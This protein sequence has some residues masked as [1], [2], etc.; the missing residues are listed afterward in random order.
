MIYGYK[1]LHRAEDWR[2]IVGIDKWVPGRSAY[3]LAYQW[4]AEKLPPS[5]RSAFDC[6]GVPELQFLRV[7]CLFVEHPT[8]LD[9]FHY[10]SCTDIIVHCR[11]S[12][13]RTVIIGVEGKATETFADPVQKWITS[14]NGEPV[15]TRL[16]RL[17]HLGQ[18]LGI[19]VPA[20]SPI[21]YQL[22]HRAASIVSESALHGATAAVVLI[23]SFAEWPDTN[24]L[25]FQ[26]FL[27]HIGVEPKPKNIVT[28]PCLL[29]PRRD[30]PTYFAWITDNPL[31][32]T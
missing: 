32:Q 4:H 2:N 19:T 9:T 27:Q 11:T 28:G 6:S 3:E 18:M 22:V 12:D 21:R 13:E 15:P 8:F 17:Q 1:Q 26:A 20:N 5:V 10:P 23:H 29:G 24:W 7:A 30:M 31:T 25:D 14:S 16:R